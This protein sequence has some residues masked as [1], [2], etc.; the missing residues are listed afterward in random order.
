MRSRFAFLL[1][2]LF[3]GFLFVACQGES[4]GQPCDTNAGN[5][6]NDDCQPPLI[7]TTGLQNANSPRCCPQ[8]RTTAKTPE[9]SLSSTA[10]EGGNPSPPDSSTPEASGP[11]TSSDGPVESATEAGT[12]TGSGAETGAGDASDGAAQDGNASDAAPD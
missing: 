1:L 12:E 9:C 5:A 3:A 2:P 4:E 11:E 7:C 6:G 8:D 10:L